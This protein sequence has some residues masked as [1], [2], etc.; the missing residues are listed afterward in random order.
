[1]LFIPALKLQGQSTI[2]SESVART[3]LKSIFLFTLITLVLMMSIGCSANQ[4]DE[5]IIDRQALVTRHNPAVASFDS[6][7][8]FTVGN[9]NFAFTVDA[10]GLQTYREHYEAGIPLGTQSNWGWHSF[11]DTLTA[12][13]DDAFEM[14]DTYGRDVPYASN[15]NSD[16]ASW[17]RSNPHR[18]H[19]G[20]IGL[21]MLDTKGERITRRRITNIDQTLNLWTGSIHSSFSAAGSPVNVTTAA[22]PNSDLIASRVS[23]NLIQDGQLE[24]KVLFPY[25]SSSWGKQTGD[26]DSPALH[27]SAVIAETSHSLVIL[28]TLDATTYYVTLTW[29]GQAEWEQR[30]PHGFYLRPQNTDAFHFTVNFSETPPD[31]DPAPTVEATLKSSAVRWAEF[32]TSGGAIDLSASTAPETA[33]LERRIILS[34][35]LIRVQESGSLPPQ[36]TGLTCNSWH[37]KFHLE[38][39]WWHG[40]HHLLW[41]RPALFERSLDWYIHALPQARE[42]A[43]RQGYSGARWPKMVGPDGRESPSGVGVFLIWQQPHPLYFLELLYQTT[44]DESI[45][46][47]FQEV[48]FATADF[49]A[50]YAQWDSAGQ[51]YNLGPP[52][53]PAQEL[54]P[55]DSTLN[56]P[57]ELTYWRFGLE[58][59]QRWRHR[60][61]MDVPPEWEHVLNNLAPLPES[62]DLYVN[63]E[64]APDTFT[65]PW[66]RNDHPTLLGAFGMLPNPEIH[67]GKMRRTLQTVMDT[68]NWQRTWGW[69]YPLTAMTAARVGEPDIAIDALLMNVQKNTYLNN[70]HNY[71]DDRLTLYLPGNGGLL[72][73]VAMMAAGWDGAPNVHAPGF[74]QDGSWKVRWEGL[75]PLP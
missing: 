35:Y 13:L 68:W 32:W 18:L 54:Y 49:M 64:N 21:H 52:L 17:L 16:E 2:P 36:E 31:V 8:S 24:I 61:N 43:E 74:P 11:P 42:K 27:S 28:R 65:D 41:G 30:T 71:Q 20:Q 38:M 3:M 34:Q 58:V 51:H 10:T 37:G 63:A 19:L 6:L 12:R 56:P 46:E 1:M 60:L 66:H 70:G 29:T 57:F 75:H 14:Y 33:E 45:L 48:V 69:D 9:G 5:T 7:S 62:D 15:T 39:H 67:A 4:M 44:K 55:P 50:D 40:V 72:T 73:A 59:A 47:K 53:I 26:W 22:H 23:S 25:G